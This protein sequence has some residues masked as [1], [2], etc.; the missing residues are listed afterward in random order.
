MTNTI[1][2]D[3]DR[4]IERMLVIKATLKPRHAPLDR[5][6]HLANHANAVAD[7]GRIREACDDLLIAVAGSVLAEVDETPAA[8]DIGRF[9]GGSHDAFNDLTF[10]DLDTVL[11]DMEAA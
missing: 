5:D 3:I 8:C 2:Q 1:A 11:N 7:A 9:R 6:Y 10:V 4:H